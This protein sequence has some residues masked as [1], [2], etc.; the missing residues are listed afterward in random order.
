MPIWRERIQMPH[1][2]HKIDR[3]TVF[4][5]WIVG[6]SVRVKDRNGKVKSGF[7]RCVCS[8]GTRR[9]VRA[10]NLIRGIS[11]SCGCAPLTERQKEQRV[12]ASAFGVKARQAIYLIKT[13]K[14]TPTPPPSPPISATKL[15]RLAL[16]RARAIKLQAVQS[17]VENTVDELPECG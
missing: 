12:K 4:G 5:F 15:E 2:A 6:D 3:G 1:P 16:I 7:Y 13:E 17:L 8:C 11:R 14:N 9:L 10:A